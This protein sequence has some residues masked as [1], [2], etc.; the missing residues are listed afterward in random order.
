MR[1][2]NN[3]ALYEKIMQNVSKQVKKALNESVGEYYVW[4][5]NREDG[6]TDDMSYSEIETYRLGWLVGGPY[7]LEQ[8]IEAMKKAVK[9]EVTDDYYFYAIEDQ[10]YED[11]AEEHMDDDDYVEPDP[12]KLTNDE[13]FK[14]IK[15]Y[16]YKFVTSRDKK[17]V[18]FRI[19]DEANTMEWMI[20]TQ[21]EIEER[22]ARYS[23]SNDE[24]EDDEFWD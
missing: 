8:A 5:A 20:L 13:L 1:R 22:K 23:K 12:D 18:T 19:H 10:W 7:T 9:N 24:D 21:E 16:S 2:N 15:K 17:H 3:K 4:F 14:L 11:Y 6:E